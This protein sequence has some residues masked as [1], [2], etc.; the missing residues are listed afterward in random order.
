MDRRV[1]EFLWRIIALCGRS[2]FYFT[3]QKIIL[4]ERS[5]TTIKVYEIEKKHFYYHNIDVISC[6][7]LSFW[8]TL[9]CL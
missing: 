4:S 3:I 5:G 7:T 6:F 8:I 9:H 1:P 2:H